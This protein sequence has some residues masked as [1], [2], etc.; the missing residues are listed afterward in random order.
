MYCSKHGVTVESIEMEFECDHETACDI[1]GICE[2]GYRHGFQG[3]YPDFIF[4]NDPNWLV[5]K[6]IDKI[7]D[8]L[9]ISDGKVFSFYS[10]A[11]SQGLNDRNH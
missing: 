7:E 3:R 5:G 11:H 8:F 6:E 4:S 1:M 10:E 2:S 9:D